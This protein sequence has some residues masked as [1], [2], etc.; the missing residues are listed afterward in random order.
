MQEK[1]VD[2]CFKE[3]SCDK[4][5]I[6][7]SNSSGSIH[8]MPLSVLPTNH[9]FYFYLITH[10]FLKEI[11]FNVVCTPTLKRMIA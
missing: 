8:L 7:N 1:G 9:F 6:S 4:L 10:C 5:S 11:G 2:M 3:R